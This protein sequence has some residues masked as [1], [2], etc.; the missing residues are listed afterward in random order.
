MY[1]ILL[2]L[3]YLIRL[4]VEQTLLRVKIVQHYTHPFLES[5]RSKEEQGGA[6][7][8]EDGRGDRRGESE[9][10]E[11]EV[12]GWEASGD[13][14][15][16]WMGGQVMEIDGDRGE[17]SWMEAQDNDLSKRDIIVVSK[18]SVPRCRGNRTFP[19]SSS[20]RRITANPS[21]VYH[22][23]DNSGRGRQHHHC[24]QKAHSCFMTARGVFAMSQTLVA[25]LG[26]GDTFAIGALQLLPQSNPPPHSCGVD[27]VVSV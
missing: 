17:D 6:R 14:G 27:R 25:K 22:G 15:D 11:I 10:M 13:V 12:S 4:V 16:E 3:N 5:R 26:D 19:G 2:K 7:S 9:W 21:Q 24:G 20:A 23:P 18:L 8:G 1:N